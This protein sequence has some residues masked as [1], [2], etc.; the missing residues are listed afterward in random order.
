MVVVL[1]VTVI[2][3]P[4]C[5]PGDHVNVPPGTVEVAVNVAGCPAQTVALLT[6]ITG[7]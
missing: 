2:V 6:E 3:F 1:G 7:T 4:L 5:P